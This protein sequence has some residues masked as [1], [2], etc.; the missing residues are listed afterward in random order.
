MSAFSIIS[1]VITAISFV[2]LLGL[3]IFVIVKAIIQKV[4]AKKEIKSNLVEFEKTKGRKY[5]K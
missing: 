4:K 2:W 5:E 1:L 3:A